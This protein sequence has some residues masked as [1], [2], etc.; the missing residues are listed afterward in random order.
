[1]GVDGLKPGSLVLHVVVGI[2]I[3]IRVINTRVVNGL[4]VQ[5]TRERAQVPA[6]G[7]Q[8][9]QQIPQQTPRQIPRQTPPQIPRQIPQQT[10]QRIP[11][12]TPQQTPPQILQQL[13]VVILVLTGMRVQPYKNVGFMAMFQGVQIVLLVFLL[14]K[15]YARP[16]RRVIGIRVQAN[17]QDI[18]V[19][20]LPS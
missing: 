20:N 11:H 17:V 5:E 12:R 10:P 18:P 8:N 9:L 14:Q 15:N 7:V 6:M 4:L 16:E 2:M 1:M 19:K 13:H 3:K